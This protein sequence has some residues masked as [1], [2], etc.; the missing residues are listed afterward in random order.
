MRPVAIVFRPS[1]TKLHNVISR[2]QFTGELPQM[3]AQGQRG[4]VRALGKDH[5]VRVKVQ[6]PLTQG[7]QGLVQFQS[8]PTGGEG[9]HEDVQVRRDASVVVLFLEM[10]LHSLLRQGADVSDIVLVTVQERMHVLGVRE[11]LDLRLVL[12]LPELPPHTVQHHLGQGPQPR[13]LLNLV[14]VEADPLGGLVVSQVLPF[15]R[16]GHVSAGP[17][18][19][20]HLEFEPGI[21]VILKQTHLAP[22][23]MPH[24]VHGQNVVSQLQ[25]FLQLGGAPGP[26]QGPLVVRVSAFVHFVKQG[27]VHVGL[28]ATPTQGEGQFFMGT[29]RQHGVK[30]SFGR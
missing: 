23:K 26:G 10:H 16:L 9:R 27:S 22:R 28:H 13:V 8:R 1:R 29:V 5:R 7:L 14:V 4:F 12:P 20:F 3:I 11:L 25:G 18:A 21:D 30:Q 24:L 15:F 6:D 19:G 17:P 2:V